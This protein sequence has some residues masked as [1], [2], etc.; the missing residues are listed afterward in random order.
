MVA[1]S[2]EQIQTRMDEHTRVRAKRCHLPP[3]RRLQLLMPPAPQPE[4]RLDAIG[5]A[6]VMLQE[7]GENA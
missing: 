7:G 2:P 5:T 6:E 4:W 1:L 3:I